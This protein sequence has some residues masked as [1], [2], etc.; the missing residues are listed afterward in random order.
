MTKTEIAK[1]FSIGKFDEVIHYIADDAIWEVVEEDKFVGKN[2]IIE[3]C[4]LVG[5]YYRSVTTSF[6]MLNVISED[7]M[8]AVNGTAELNR[9]GKQ[10]SFVS[11]CDIY[12]FNDFDQIQKITSNCIKTK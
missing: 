11:A 10:A 12:S 3:N 8:V 9:D 2:A 1:A 5:H 6:K 4:N 7:D